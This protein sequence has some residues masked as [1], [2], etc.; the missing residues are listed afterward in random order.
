MVRLTISGDCGNAS[1]L[2]GDLYTD[3]GIGTDTLARK[4]VR[5]SVKGIEDILDQCEE[6]S[7]L[8]TK[9]SH[10]CTLRLR[11]VL[12]YKSLTS[13]KSECSERLYKCSKY[14]VLT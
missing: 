5:E 2:A 13:S 9:T 7:D 1:R 3:L 10:N 14:D 12:L 6:V 4:Q 8:F 11:V